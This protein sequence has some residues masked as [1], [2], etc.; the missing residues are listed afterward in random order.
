PPGV[1]RWVLSDCR[2]DSSAAIGGVTSRA[3]PGTGRDFERFCATVAG[4]LDT[5]RLATV[6]GRRLSRHVVPELPGLT[7]ELSGTSQK[8]PALVT[9][10]ADVRVSADGAALEHAGRRYQLYP[11]DVSGP[12]FL[13]LSLPCLVPVP[14]ATGRR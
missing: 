5:S 9:A 2:D 1:G 13:S 4:W 3:Q 10:A 6:L 7:V 12:L 11:G 8:P 14:F